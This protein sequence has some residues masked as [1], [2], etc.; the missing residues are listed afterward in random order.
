MSDP[1]ASG[2]D[3][4]ASTAGAPGTEAAPAAVVAPG[5]YPDASGAQRWW[6]G[7]AWTDHV[8]PAATSAYAAAG[9]AGY[10][11]GYQPGY[12]PGYAQN[13]PLSDRPA[14]PAGTTVDTVWVWIV[15]LV[16]SLSLVALFFFDMNA[17]MESAMDNTLAGRPADPFMGMGTYYLATYGLSAILYA[18]TVFAAFRDYRHLASVGV[19][20]PFH[21]AFA[22]IPYTLVYLIGRHVVLRKVTK[23]S[24]A[25]LWAH[26]GTLVLTFII[27]MVW[28]F[29]LFATMMQSIPTRF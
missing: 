14:L 17:V 15:A 12:A 18:A 3:P 20:R 5:W 26:I 11:G 21:W 28:G 23:T 13:L 10:Q 4:T 8:A 24:G 22:F 7:V 6:D 16:N 27:S 2:Y 1:T 29:A 25:P 9:T 19:V